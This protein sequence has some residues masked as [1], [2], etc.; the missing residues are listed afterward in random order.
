[1]AKKRTKTRW[2][3]G[4]KN[5]KIKK[6]KTFTMISSSVAFSFF[7]SGVECFLETQPNLA[8]LAD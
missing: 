2:I 6:S 3:F 7:F 4:K 1:M 8:A 5:K